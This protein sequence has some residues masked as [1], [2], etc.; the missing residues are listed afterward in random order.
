MKPD[1]RWLRLILALLL[2]GTTLAAAQEADAELTPY[3]ILDQAKADAGSIPAQA[4][5]LVRHAW[6]DEPGDSEVM[7]LARQQLVGTWP[8]DLAAD[9]DPAIGL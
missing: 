7:A 1:L 2:L 9:G 4:L 5:A 3:Q 6:P 8:L